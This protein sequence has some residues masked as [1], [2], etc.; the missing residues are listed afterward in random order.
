MTDYLYSVSL[1]WQT[2]AF[3]LSLGFGFI[4]GILYDVFR[5]VR[6]CVSERKASF[7]IFDLLY[8]LTLCICSFLFFLTVNEGEVRL[9]IIIG[10]TAGFL[11]WYFSLGAVVFSVSG[12]IIAFIKRTVHTVFKIILF[13]FKWIFGRF[14]GFF[15]KILKKSRKNSKNIKNK[16]NFLLKVNKHMLYNLYNKKNTVDDVLSEEREA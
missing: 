5:I 16:S 15:N 8:C 13:P 3:L 14:Y 2:K 11:V 7:V 9:F 6:L 4:M 10:E 12:K 1:A